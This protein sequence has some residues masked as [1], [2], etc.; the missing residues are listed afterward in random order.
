V[1]D[2]RDAVLLLSGTASELL[3]AQPQGIQMLVMETVAASINYWEDNKVVLDPVT[4]EAVL[5][6]IVVVNI[7]TCQGYA[8]LVTQAR[9]EHDET[10]TRRPQD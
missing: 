7:A 4:R 2:L 5:D 9:E 3:L 6:S 1:A 8:A 10:C